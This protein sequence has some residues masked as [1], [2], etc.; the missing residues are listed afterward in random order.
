M[1]RDGALKPKEAFEIR[2][3]Q[4]EMLEESLKRNIIV[5]V[6]VVLAESPSQMASDSAEMDRWKQDLGKHSCKRHISF[7][8]V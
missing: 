1:A 7:E 4:L 3:Y 8:I 2:S 5:A 6:R